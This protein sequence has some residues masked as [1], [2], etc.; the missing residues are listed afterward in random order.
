MI[1]NRKKSQNLQSRRGFFE[2]LESRILL[3]VAGPVDDT[4]NVSE[5]MSLVV[6]PKDG[7]LAN[8]AGV[9]QAVLVSGP[10]AGGQLIFSK[11]G[12][13]GYRP[14]PDFFGADTFVYRDAASNATA[15]VT[16]NVA[17]NSNV[18]AAD[19]A[20][21]MRHDTLLVIN[22][23]DEG[24][25]NNDTGVKTA[26][27]IQG[28]AHGKVELHA[29]GTFNYK[30]DPGFVGVDTFSYVGI[31]QN[32]SDGG[33]VTITVTNETP[34]AVGD[35][36][37]TDEDTP[38]VVENGLL[39]NDSD[40]DGDKLSV[41]W[42][43]GPSH[44]TLEW[45]GNDK[46][47][48]TYTP[49]ANFNGT[50]A[51]RYMAYD[52]IAY[53]DPVTVTITVNPVADAPVGNTDTYATDEDTQ[54]VV[55]APGVLGNDTDADGDSLTV[56]FDEAN[57]PQ[58]G[59]LA[60]NADGSFTYTPNL[61]FHGTDSFQYSVTDGVFT[62]ALT[63]V[64]LTVNSVNDIPVAGDDAYATDEDTPLTVE[65]PG[66]FVNDTDADGELPILGG[67]TSPQH[68]TLV[69]EADGSFT[70][71]PDAN[72]FGTDSFQYRTR[73]ELEYSNWATVTITVNPVNDAP[74]AV[75]DSYETWNEEFV[76]SPEAGMLANDSDVDDPVLTVTLVTTPNV[77]GVI[78]SPDGSFVYSPVPSGSDYTATF[79]YSVVDSGGLSDTATVSIL[80]K[81]NAV[82]N[83][84]EYGVLEDTVLQGS[85][86]ENDDNVG[87]LTIGM[88]QAPE[89][90]FLIM[91][92][93]G[94]FS[95]QPDPDF[96]GTDTFVYTAGTL[97]G[98]VT[99]TVFE[100]I[101]TAAIYNDEGFKTSDQ[102]AAGDLDKGVSIVQDMNN[103][104]VNLVAKTGVMSDQ[105][106]TVQE[107]FALNY[108]L[109][110]NYTVTEAGNP[111]WV[112]GSGNPMTRELNTG[113][114]H[115][116]VGA[117][118]DW[119]GDDA[120]GR[121]EYGTW[122]SPVESGYHLIQNDGGTTTLEGTLGN[123]SLNPTGGT[124]TPFWN[125]VIDGIF[126]MGND[127]VR[128]NAGT[129]EFATDYEAGVDY[130]FL[131]NEDG[132]QNESLSD[133]ADWLTFLLS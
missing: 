91:D 25:L 52:G 105:V 47:S 112:D 1:R 113:A 37:A 96:V 2:S 73:D 13:F 6:Q 48:F 129:L 90:G 65:A 68:G 57:G 27:L 116:Y 120:G 50:D 107:L 38:L 93:L 130:Y 106:I 103:A 60:L 44:G 46:G 121:L 114:T 133:V 104:V 36:Y 109:I 54:L 16:I 80:V 72:F 100:D 128:D 61:N 111:I 132:D 125:N 11:N 28:P 7:V 9:R 39:V 5:D 92:E 98:N 83:D 117:W 17:A 33:V 12:G 82:V 8:D 118:G 42:L 81:A 71:T 20:Y 62:S 32:G 55:E 15:T 31:G 94:S 84:D 29:K 35:A 21:N 97:V 4:Y 56:V 59:V 58:N 45:R 127:I 89:H 99:I 87:G 126:H 53:S 22:T 18:I 63:T 10:T 75:D 79:T 95:Y 40:A 74:V 43:D 69:L 115:Y 122:G 102:L 66:V 3:T 101:V 131:L 78:Y 14:A 51:F 108:Y 26:S 85:V 24:V 70:Y 23:P 77:G 49:D 124:G 88:S 76:V 64:N 123:Y 34:V 30:P 119:H 110:A 19:D 67:E 86:T 41:V